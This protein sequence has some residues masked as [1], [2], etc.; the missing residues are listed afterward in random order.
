[1]QFAM[2]HNH[3]PVLIGDSYY[4]IANKRIQ[5]AMN[6]LFDLFNSSAGRILLTALSSVSLYRPGPMSWIVLFPTDSR[7]D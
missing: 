3:T 2:R 5:R 6:D 1:M 7:Q 4:P